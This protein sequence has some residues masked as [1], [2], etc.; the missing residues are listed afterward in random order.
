MAEVDRSIGVGQHIRQILSL[1]LGHDKNIHR[2]IGVQICIGEPRDI[3]P[4]RYNR[5]FIQII[6]FFCVYF[7]LTRYAGEEDDIGG[8]IAV[9]VELGCEVVGDGLVRGGWVGD[10]GIPGSAV[11]VDRWKGTE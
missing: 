6:T 2:S 7:K 10:E 5:I 3:H 8:A 9:D 11:T 4:Q 1:L